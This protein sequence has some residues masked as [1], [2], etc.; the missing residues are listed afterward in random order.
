ME[1]PT[2]EEKINEPANNI[3]FQIQQLVHDQRREEQE[4]LKFSAFLGFF[5]VPLALSIILIL[6]FISEPKQFIWSN[7]LILIAISFAFSLLYLTFYIFKQINFA[8]RWDFYTSL[9]VNML[10]RALVGELNKDYNSTMIRLNFE[11]IQQYYTQTKH[12]ANKSFGVALF[13]CITGFIIIGAGIVMMLFGKSEPAY[14]TTITGVIIEGISSMFFYLYN[15]TISQM[16]E[17]HQRLLLSQNINI[18]SKITEDMDDQS[19]AEAQ[20]LIIDRL[21][22]NTNALISKSSLMDSGT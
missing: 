17:Y 11:F 4:G 14:L 18:A 5:F 7:A 1:N 22:S 12:H 21:T 2:N 16:S 20:K 15:K 3:D 8:R 6:I 9:G 19:K 13:A 10:L